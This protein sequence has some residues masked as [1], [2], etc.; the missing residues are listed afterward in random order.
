MI[1][2]VI[3]D[4]F[5]VL[6]LRNYETLQHIYFKDDEEKIKLAR[7]LQ[8]ELGLGVIS[9]E[10]Y[11]T[12]LSKISGLHRGLVLKYTEDYKP[13]TALLDYIRMQLKPKYKIG[14]ISNA[15]ADWVIEILGEENQKLFDSIILSYKVGIIKPTPE[16][17][18]VSAENLDVSVKECIFIDDIYDFCQGAESVGMKS[19][20]YRDYWHMK[21]ELENLLAVSNN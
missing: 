10:D 9:Y 12:G 19:I 20:W 18:K 16:I 13:N 4:F 11:I 14:I 15:G 7:K 8:D 2:A 5:G 21:T 1:K 3:F 17:Y 6:A